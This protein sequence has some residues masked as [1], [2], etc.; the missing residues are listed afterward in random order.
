MKENEFFEAQTLS[1]SIKA[2]IISEYF[3]KYAKII[4][5]KHTPKQIRYIDLFSGPGIYDDGNISTPI[6]VGRKC[7]ND[8]FLKSKVW[9]IFNDCEYKEVL[10]RNFEKEFPCGTFSYKPF[11]ADRT[12]GQ[13]ESVTTFLTRNTHEG[14]HN[15]APSLLFIDPF[16]YKGIQTSVLSQFLR[17]WGNEIF[18]FINIKRIH[19]AL[20]NDN[21]ESLMLDWFPT[22]Y[23]QLKKERLLKR[24][25]SE[26]LNLI[27]DKLGEEYQKILGGQV[28]YTAFK[29]QEE[30]MDATS[31][32]ILH[33]T[34]GMKGFE[35]IKTI[36]NDFANVGTIFDGV[37]TYT[38]DIKKG[39]NPIAELFDTKSENID[40]LK[41]ELYNIYRGRNL[42]A[43][44][45]FD[46]HH[47]GG[48]YCA[49]HYVT[50]LRRLYD[51]DKLSADYSDD[52][53]HRYSVLLS[54]FCHLKFK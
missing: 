46:E 31:H 26:R 30:D 36:Y 2:S 41:D 28:F 32:Y 15:E 25:V 7:A 5:A 29:F 12:I 20:E 1:S 45:L 39:S 50:A 40:V 24:S 44:E 27:I 14:K 38:F 23:T 9:L 17:N 18:I 47:I 13:S 10:Q 33:L 11:F 4:A 49:S 6:L 22:S 51:E 34:K 3:P 54:D 19:A 52:K 43:K 48:L 53:K 42:T 8:G 37:N 35:L 21:F 16:G